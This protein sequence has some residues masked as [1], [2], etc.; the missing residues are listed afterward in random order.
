MVCLSIL[1]MKGLLVA[2]SGV[3]VFPS[4]VVFGFSMRHL[5]FGLRCADFSVV[6]PLDYKIN[7][8]I[9]WE[10]QQRFIKYLL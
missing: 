7:T 8:I 5:K 6:I 4:P 3:L 1:L 10:V 9:V 2:S